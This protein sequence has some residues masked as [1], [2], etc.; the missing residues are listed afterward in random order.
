MEESMFQRLNVAEKR[1]DLCAE[2]APLF[3]DWAREKAGE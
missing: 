1:L 3:A 2:I